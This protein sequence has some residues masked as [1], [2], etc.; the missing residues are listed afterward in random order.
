MA[1]TTVS[2]CIGLSLLNPTN[3]ISSSSKVSSYI[4][5]SFTATFANFSFSSNNAQT[6][7]P[8]SDSKKTVENSSNQQ[9]TDVDFTSLN[10]Y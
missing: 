6:S 1:Y 8:S 10:Q 7:A 4:T 9:N 2:Y 3:I 5:E